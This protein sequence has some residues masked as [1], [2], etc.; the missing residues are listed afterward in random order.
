[1]FCYTFQQSDHAVS[2]VISEQITQRMERADNRPDNRVDN[3][4]DCNEQLP[5]G[6]NR[7]KEHFVN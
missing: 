6:N 4:M 2:P 1:M 5:A 7:N 3:R